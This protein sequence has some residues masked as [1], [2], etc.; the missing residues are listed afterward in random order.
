LVATFPI[1]KDDGA[2]RGIA[3]AVISLQWIDE[4]A[5]M[6]AKHSGASVLL[7]D[8]RGAV[9]AGSADQHGFVGI[10][11][12]D[13]PLTQQMLAAENGTVS[14][15]GFDGVQRLYAFVRI[16]WTGANL[17]VGL[18]ENAI[19]HGIDRETAIAG[20]QLAACCIFVLLL[21]WFGRE[22]FVVRPITPLVRT[23]ARFGRGDLHVRATTSPGSP[24]SSRSRQHLTIWRQSSPR[25][26]R[27]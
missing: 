12:A 17:A 22:Y 19:R 3:L 23:A 9:I 14:A 24:S 26:R 18:D 4:L 13:D 5:S 27:N 11:F 2:L 20:L 21:A 16:P 15:A 6:A 7:I 8:S 25:A 1:I 10:Q